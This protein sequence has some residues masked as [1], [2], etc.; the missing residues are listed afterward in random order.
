[1]YIYS[2]SSRKLPDHFFLDRIARKMADGGA[3]AAASGPLQAWRERLLA[4]NVVMR[5]DYAWCALAAAFVAIM[6]SLVAVL[7]R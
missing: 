5:Y 7:R 2:S 6:R 3:D 1:M 4:A